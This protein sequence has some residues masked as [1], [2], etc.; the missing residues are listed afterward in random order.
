ML[1]TEQH[2]HGKCA[3]A[4]IPLTMVNGHR[5][6]YRKSTYAVYTSTSMTIDNNVIKEQMRSFD[7]FNSISFFIVVRLIFRKRLAL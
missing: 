7:Y 1:I 4:D 5:T 3:V 2:K 6:Q